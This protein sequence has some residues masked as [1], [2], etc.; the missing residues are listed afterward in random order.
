MHAGWRTLF[1]L[2][3]ASSC[4]GG[5]PRWAHA[6]EDLLRLLAVV[7]VVVMHDHATVIVREEHP[8]AQH[9]AVGLEAKERIAILEEV[10]R[11]KRLVAG[12][13]AVRK[14]E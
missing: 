13:G 7:P 10:L 14:Q 9:G 4:N 6:V 1:R 11:S 2:W 3:S 5:C 12:Q 8:D